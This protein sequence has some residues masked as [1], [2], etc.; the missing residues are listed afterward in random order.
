MSDAVQPDALTAEEAAA[1]AAL[2][3]VAKRWP[4]TLTLLSMSGTLH[5]VRT[6]DGRL[7]LDGPERCDASLATIAG[8]PNDGGDW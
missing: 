5:V 1:I 6:G 3:R 4:R 2:R 8:I 7:D